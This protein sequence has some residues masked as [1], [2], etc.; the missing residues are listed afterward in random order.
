MPQP[1]HKCSEFG[2][3]ILKNN[4]VTTT[5]SAF[6][7]ST[8]NEASFFRLIAHEILRGFKHFNSPA[9]RGR[10]R[11]GY[12]AHTLLTPPNSHVGSFHL[13]FNMAVRLHQLSCKVFTFRAIYL[14]LNRASFCSAQGGSLL[15]EEE[16]YA[17]LKDLGLKA[18]NDG[19]FNGTWSARGE[20]S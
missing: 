3:F 16:K 8:R 5:Q 1:G 6:T 9:E 10:R 4:F 17:W 18:E 13:G 20:V 15:I 12:E 11:S 19:V 7:C 14:G 2:V